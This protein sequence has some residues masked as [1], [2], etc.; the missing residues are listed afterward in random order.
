M[1]I[2]PLYST[3]HIYQICLSRIP[4]W[5]SRK[6]SAC[7]AG[8]Y[9]QCKRREFDTGLEQSAGEENGNLLHY[10]C[11]ENPMD[12]RTC[13]ATYSPWGHKGQ[14]KLSD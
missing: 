10:T 13:Q 3:Y 7:N 2:V 8:D 1:Y 5:L 9:L 12:R 4:Q 14:T 11:L 6:E